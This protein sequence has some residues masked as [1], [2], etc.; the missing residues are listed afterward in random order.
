MMGIG[1]DGREVGRQ[2]IKIADERMTATTMASGA[3]N[4]SRSAIMTTMTADGMT[5]AVVILVTNGVAGV[6]RTGTTMTAA[7][8]ATGIM[9]AGKMM[10]GETEGG[11]MGTANAG[12]TKTIDATVLESETEIVLVVR[13]GT[14]GEDIRTL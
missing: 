14:I 2:A 11:M 3:A 10:I 13:I 1:I 7:V 8:T 5:T 12:E 9:I 4:V 6:I